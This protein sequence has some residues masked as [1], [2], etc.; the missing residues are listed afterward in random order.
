MDS[1]TSLASNFCNINSYLSFS[2]Y[3]FGNVF[4]TTFD[5][6]KNS[7][8]SVLEYLKGRFVDLQI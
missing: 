2:Q 6:T 1:E 7:A 8:R 3:L 5:F 4:N